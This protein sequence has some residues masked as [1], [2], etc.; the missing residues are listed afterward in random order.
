MAEEGY[1]GQAERTLQFAASVAT[2]ECC[3][4][5]LVFW[6]STRLSQRWRDKGETFYCPYGHCQSYRETSPVHKLEKKLEAMKGDRDWWKGA[7][8]AEAKRHSST[9]GQVT[10]LR[11]RIG[12]GVCPCCKRT[13]KGLAAHMEKK[14]PDYGKA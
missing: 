10:K 13:F 8:G 7:H 2:Q 14:H 3:E 6:V 4:C 5:G 1:V 11:R 12:A 9:K